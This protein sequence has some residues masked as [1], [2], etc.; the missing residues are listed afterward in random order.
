[1]LLFFDRMQD[2]IGKLRLKIMIVN[3]IR[4]EGFLGLYAGIKFDLLRILPS[5]AITFIT[6]EHLRSSMIV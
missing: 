4:K 5:N 3:T 6:Y 2:S 1:M